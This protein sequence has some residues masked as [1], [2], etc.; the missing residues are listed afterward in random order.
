MARDGKKLELYEVLA[1]KK[2]KGK[3]P[4][5]FENNKIRQANSIDPEP[6]GIAQVAPEGGNPGIIID[7]AVS[8]EVSLPRPVPEMGE[9]QTYATAWEA[10]T[11]RAQERQVAPIAS[12]AGRVTNS[13]AP[14]SETFGPNREA[15]P[16][17]SVATVH[18]PQAKASMA[19]KPSPSKKEGM[20]KT[21]CSRM[22]LAKS[23]W[24]KVGN[25]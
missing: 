25:N 4:L 13:M 1:A 12:P 14:L 6:D 21:S 15:S 22:V 10:K 18:R 8:A 9:R 17:I 2:A 16:S 19:I 7:D 24:G 3:T 20:T 11:N 23:S 5:G